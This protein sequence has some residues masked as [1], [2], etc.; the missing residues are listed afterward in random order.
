MKESTANIRQ[1]LYYLTG[2]NFTQINKLVLYPISPSLL[3]R[4]HIS[5][6]L[7]C[8]QTPFNYPN[9]FPRVAL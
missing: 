4:C 2:S 7:S 8:H 9:D 5:P 6:V 3:A 1:E